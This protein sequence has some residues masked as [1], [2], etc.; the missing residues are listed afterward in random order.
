M[1]LARVR[2]PQS[3]KKSRPSR[4][5]RFQVIRRLHSLPGKGWLRCPAFS[6]VCSPS[7]T[8]LSTTRD[9]VWTEGCLRAFD[10]PY[11]KPQT[12]RCPS[13]MHVDANDERGSYVAA[14]GYGGVLHHVCYYSYKSKD[15]QH[16]YAA[17]ENKTFPTSG[18]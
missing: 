2:S 3:W 7:T 1:S 17:T 13:A 11:F 16:R 12:Y 4:S 10:I 14:G 15:N 9:Y 5:T 18:S 8:L 6:Q